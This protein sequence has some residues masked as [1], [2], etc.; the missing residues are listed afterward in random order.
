VKHI[1]LERDVDVLRAVIDR[2]GDDLNRVDGDLHDDLTTLFRELQRE[3]AA[4]AVLLTGR[5][6]A[7]SAGGH[8]DWLPALQEPGALESL[9]LDGKQLVWDLLDVHLP[10]VCA[11][12]GHA[13]GFGASIRPGVSPVASPPAH[14]W[15]CST[16]S[17]Q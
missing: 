15:R 2:S 14:P 6:R 16:P 1:E 10:I 12:D 4:R 13:V 8:F 7:F 11:L 3:R 5:G 9:R 17:S